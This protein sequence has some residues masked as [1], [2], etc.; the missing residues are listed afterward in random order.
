MST[1]LDNTNIPIINSF[2]PIKLEE[3]NAVRLMK[4]TDTKFVFHTNQLEQ[5]LDQASSNYKLLEV[6]GFRQIPYETIYFDTP[7]YKMYHSHHNGKLHRFKIRHRTYSDSGL[8]FLEIKNKSNKGVTNKKRIE[9][10]LDAIKVNS[11]SEFLETHSPFNMDEVVPALWTNFTRMTLVHK[12]SP[13][14]ITID[15][16]LKFR[17]VD[18]NEELCNPNLCIAEVKKGVSNDRSDFSDIL[19]QNRIN[20]MGF[21][22]Y[23]MGMASLNK[24]VKTNLFKSRLKIVEKITK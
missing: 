10:E 11:G 24:K 3:M 4:R 13:E 21:S 9:Q 6:D 15:L 8:A 17:D 22:K 20:P 18:S 16:N 2:E 14:R 12:S 7:D 23:C 19:K 1:N 5:I